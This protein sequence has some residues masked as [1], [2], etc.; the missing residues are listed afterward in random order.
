LLLQMTQAIASRCNMAC[1]HRIGWLACRIQLLTIQ[2]M[3]VIRVV[4]ATV[5]TG[6][7]TLVHMVLSRYQVSLR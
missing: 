1:N 4:V 2:T 7:A 5:V 3:I 6:L